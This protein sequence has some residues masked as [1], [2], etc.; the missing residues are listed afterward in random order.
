[1]LA[2]ARV[3]LTILGAATLP[4]A[5]EASRSVCGKDQLIRAA[6]CSGW[7]Y[8]RTQTSAPQAEKVSGAVSRGVQVPSARVSSARRVR[9]MI[10]TVRSKIGAPSPT[11]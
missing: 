10:S 9:V 7:Y 6:I 4:N 5:S 2:V 8:V 11:G 3:R 1:M